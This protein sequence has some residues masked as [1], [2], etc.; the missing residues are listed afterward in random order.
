[1]SGKHNKILKI[2]IKTALSIIGGILTIIIAFLSYNEDA[3]NNEIQKDSLG[4]QKKEANQNKEVELSNV[5]FFPLDIYKSSLDHFEEKDKIKFYKACVLEMFLKNPNSRPKTINEWSVNTKSITSFEYT[6]LKVMPVFLDDYNL[7]IFAINNGNTRIENANIN[8]DFKYNINDVDGNEMTFQISNY[9]D[10]NESSYIKNIDLN[11]GELKKIT[12]LKLPEDVKENLKIV[13]V[14]K[15]VPYLQ[16]YANCQINKNSREE[17]FS[18]KFFVC[19]ISYY[20][21]SGYEFTTFQGDGTVSNRCIYINTEMDN[22]KKIQLK[23][24]NTTVSGEEAF[25]ITLIPD[26]PCKIEYVIDVCIDDYTIKSKPYT[27]IIMT[28]FYKG[29]QYAFIELSQYIK[30]NYKEKFTKDDIPVEN[31]YDPKEVYEIIDTNNK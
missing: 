7:I 21:D 12:A 10:A 31:F 15:P 19:N 6:D 2:D 16:L 20:S 22:N 4:I 14:R 1:M 5:D 9:L 13:D 23:T 8:I 30:S 28:P 26:K 18:E 3:K 17:I 27:S 11:I 29:E 25:R 24:E